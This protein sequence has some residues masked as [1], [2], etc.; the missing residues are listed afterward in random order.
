MSSPLEIIRVANGY[1]CK[2]A[3]PPIGDRLYTTM[4]GEIRVFQTFEAMV[5]FLSEWF[6]PKDGDQ[7]DD[8]D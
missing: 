6:E 2:P 8:R 1:I 7:S 3:D 4:R 5:E